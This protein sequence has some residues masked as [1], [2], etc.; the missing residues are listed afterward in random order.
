MPRR[1]AKVRVTAPVDDVDLPLQRRGR[2]TLLIVAI[3]LAVLLMGVRIWW[4]W[5][6]ERR[7][8][9]AVRELQAVGAL[10]PE[11]PPAGPI[12]D[13]E[14]NAATFIRR[15]AAAAERD[16]TAPDLGTGFDFDQVPLPPNALTS[17]TRLI[18]AN[19]D[20]LREMREARRIGTVWWNESTADYDLSENLRVS[21]ARRVGM[22]IRYAVLQAHATGD[23]AQAVERIRDVIFL[24]HA[25][26]RERPFFAVAT[27]V[28]IRVIAC[29]R[30]RVICPTLR[31]GPEPGAAPAVAV[32]ALCDELVNEQMF[33]ELLLSHDRASAAPT[34]DSIR[35]LRSGAPG[36][37]D[38]VTSAPPPHWLDTLFVRVAGPFYAMQGARYLVHRA[39]VIRALQRKDLA[40]VRARFPPEVSGPAR[41][42]LFGAESP[43][44][45]FTSTADF[46]WVMSLWKGP[47]VSHLAAAQLAI[48]SYA[49]GNDGRLPPNLAA[50]VPKY[51]SAVPTDPFAP[52]GTPIGYAPSAPRPF[53]Y[54][55]WD[56]GSDTIASGRWKVPPT[57]S[58]SDAWRQPNFVWF[59]GSLSRPAPATQPTTSGS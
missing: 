53:V 19:P 7:L 12:P 9:A 4:G 32:R 29:N 42:G 37:I 59:L 36:S 33:A 23:D 3:A 21:Q 43:S 30:V 58:E 34:L 44:E 40:S 6:A 57:L 28:N 49:L 47:T 54:S 26:E 11:T 38:G 45:A 22:L 27:S 15:A 51:L 13:D 16:G 5:V 10:T 2:V 14:H 56:S 48:R 41:T 25:I 35:S 39:S 31:I 52:A 18:R 55:V 17:L 50:L 24:A 8:D 1:L 46:E 20:A